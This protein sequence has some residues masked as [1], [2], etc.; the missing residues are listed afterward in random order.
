[1]TEHDALSPLDSI[2]EGCDLASAS[3]ARR[4]LLGRGRSATTGANRKARRKR[5]K[6]HREWLDREVPENIVAA[7]IAARPDLELEKRSIQRQFAYWAMVYLSA[8]RIHKSASDFMWVRVTELQAGF[9]P[10]GFTELNNALQIFDVLECAS[11]HRGTT[12]G[13]RLQAD[14]ASALRAA[15][16]RFN[17]A[18]PVEGAGSCGNQDRLPTRIVAP[19]HSLWHDAPF[20]ALTPCNTAE[21]VRLRSDLDAILELPRVEQQNALRSIGYDGNLSATQLVDKIE[22][23]LHAAKRGNGFIAHAYAQTRSGR[24]V[25]IG[26]NL[27]SPPRI[28]KDAALTGLWQYDFSNCHLRIAYQLA[29]E[30]GIRMPAIDYYLRNKDVVRKHLAQVAEVSEKQAKLCLIAFGYGARR[31]TSPKVELHNIIKGTANDESTTRAKAEALCNDLFVR[32][33]IDDMNRARRAILAHHDQIIGPGLINA[34]SLPFIPKDDG[35]KV[36]ITDSQRMAHLLQGIEARMLLIATSLLGRDMVCLEHD[37]F[38]TSRRISTFRLRRAIKRETGFKMK[39]EGGAKQ[40]RNKPAQQRKHQQR[41]A[42]TG[43]KRE[44]AITRDLNS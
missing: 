28:V 25:A 3:R 20:S 44:K 32:S 19:E 33:L 9:R 15:V 16:R 38:S 11:P 14:I 5:Q 31:S 29:Y 41:G 17:D 43:R 12:K 6:L 36:K 26:A 10:R 39:I 8:A 40:P 2:D 30:L 34:M 27:Q 7:L 23:L 22:E 24:M 35:P 18:L 37:G 4:R 1:M 21:L 42:G 13:Y